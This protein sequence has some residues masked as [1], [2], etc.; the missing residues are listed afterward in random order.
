MCICQNHAHPSRLAD[1][2]PPSL[3]LP[4]TNTYLLAFSGSPPCSVFLANVTYCLYSLWSTRLIYPDGSSTPRERERLCSLY[5]SLLWAPWF[6]GRCTA[7]WLSKHKHSF[8]NSSSSFRKGTNLY[9]EARGSRAHLPELHSVSLQC[10]EVQVPWPIW[11]PEASSVQ[12]VRNA[13][14]DRRAPTGAL[15]R[16]SLGT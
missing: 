10:D 2:P 8:R 15:L 14:E 11:A 16:L 12:D 13:K 9:S 7:E 5:V 6:F 3:N 1:I 4:A